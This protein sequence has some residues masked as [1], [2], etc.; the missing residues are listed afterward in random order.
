MYKKQRSLKKE[1]GAPGILQKTSHKGERTG[2]S[3][4][5]LELAQRTLKESESLSHTGDLYYLCWFLSI[6]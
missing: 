5:Y 4:R 6:F 1:S 2:G 3:I